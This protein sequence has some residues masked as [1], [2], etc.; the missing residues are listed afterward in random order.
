METML[1][2]KKLITG[3]LILTLGASMAAW[4]LSNTNGPQGVAGVSVNQNIA[5]P[6]LDN[7]AFY[8]SQNVD[9]PVPF[10]GTASST[11]M[12]DGVAN[13]I[14]NG[15]IAANPNGPQQDANGS[16]TFTPPD[17]Q[18]LADALQNEP[19]LQK[20]FVA[21]QW[22]QE[23]AQLQ[24][25]IKTVADSS[26]TELAYLNS[27]NDIINKQLVESGIQNAVTKLAADN[28]SDNSG[29]PSVFTKAGS[30]IFS[31]L[32][33][34]TTV[35][36]PAP[37]SA[38]QKSFIKL[39]VYEKNF[40]LL[41]QNIQQDPSDPTAAV[42]TLQYE[43]DN[44]N[45]ALQDFNDQAQKIS[46]LAMRA[47]NADVNPVTALINKIFFVNTAEAFFAIV[48]DPIHTAE[49]V[50][51][52]SSNT[53]SQWGVFFSKLAQDMLLQIGK[54]ILMALI[55]Q[56]V[57]AYIQGSGAPRFITSWATDLVN[58]GEQSA[59]SAINKNFACINV[60]TV[61]PRIQIILNALYKQNNNACA[62][63]FQSQL[64]SVNLKDFLNNFSSGGF[65]TFGQTMLPSN[66]FYG[67][68]FFT[69]QSAGQASQQSKNVF[70]LKSTA[71]QG[72]RSSQ[73]CAD[74][75]NPNGFYCWSTT[76]NNVGYN[77]APGA[78]GCNPGYGAVPN[79]G[80]CATGEAIVTMPGVVN[81]Q[82]LGEALG[83][84]PKLV[85][86]ANS[87][88]GLVNAA[89]QSLLMGLV[90]AGVNA[91][92]NLVN[93]AL[94]GDNGIMSI[95]PNSISNLSASSTVGSAL[96]C[97]P[98]NASVEEPGLATSFAGF[99]GTY[100]LNGN[101]PTYTWT[102]SDGTSGTGSTFNVT[103]N[104]LGTYTITLSDAVGDAPTTCMA[105]VTDINASST[106]TST[107]P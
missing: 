98:T 45:Q 15:L 2:V 50:L 86:A 54:N 22:D 47:N 52:I 26:S 68:L 79:N 3:F 12:T 36:V 11:N 21:P 80:D 94:Q 10:I 96:S 92:T 48:H 64:S 24:N 103:Y 49:T 39:L 56:K 4:I 66:N 104:T 14:V 89:A 9:V 93:G 87:I 67:G 69:A 81:S 75:S 82:A 105:T 70:S 44:Y 78:T 84:S 33:G 6:S 100:D 99:G 95:D 55:Q 60:N 8:P 32:T 97:L 20:N 34:I 18:A 77:P 72:Y 37:F 102:S 30:A 38:L 85:A 29:A 7:N 13:A 43:A 73:V 40:Y 59:L 31:M 61:Y 101:P 74:G 62:A 76:Q 71:A 19:A 57:L 16:T 58:A 41:V 91:A 1:D 107:L 53:A 17:P 5:T 27:F 65:V 51:G 23:V 28:S 83:G 25:H 90:N 63:T 46:L 106:A 42:I 88:A 35:P